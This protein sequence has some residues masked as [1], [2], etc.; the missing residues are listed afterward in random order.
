MLMKRSWYVIFMLN[1]LCYG[2]LPAQ[3]DDYYNPVFLQYEDYV[4]VNTINTVRLHEESWELSP[5]LIRLG[6]TQKLK[7]S[8]DDF[9]TKLKTLNYTVIHCDANWKP[10]DIMQNEYLEGFF[11]NNISDFQYS[12]NT[13]QKYVNYFL[14][15]PNT[16]FS[17][18]KSGNY[19][20][21]VYMDGDQEKL[22]LTRRFMVFEEL[23]NVVPVVSAATVIN[24]RN[25]KQEIDFTIFHSG[26]DITNAYSDL[27]VFVLQND[28]WDNASQNIKPLFIKD[29][30]M[31]FDYDD[32]NVFPGGN[33]YRYFDIK[34]IRYLSERIKSFEYDSLKNNHVYL[35]PDEKRSFK[36]YYSTVND[37]NGK[38]TVKVQGNH[39]SDIEADYTYVHFFLPYNQP[40]TEGNIYIFGGLTDWRC[41]KKNR[42]TYNAE[43]KGY[44][45]TLYLKQG[46]YNYHYAF[47]QD[48]KNIPDVTVVE[49]SHYS[50]ENDYSICVYHRSQGTFYDRLIAVK[51]VNSLRGSY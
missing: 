3:E 51:R 24:D 45:V 6:S 37:I 26:Y 9:D 4:Y 13:F 18:T 41:L 23:V 40:E 36:K 32:V 25:Y 27:K 31:V 38:Y 10:T 7:L 5:P 47:L 2:L 44:E 30:E 34:T 42:L 11:E 28:R 21:K 22:V 14:V 17:I 33:E 39:N 20:L 48:G 16:N 35:L 15:F 19:L 50:T 12:F 29:K 46:Y 1:V 49:G 8:F 43:L